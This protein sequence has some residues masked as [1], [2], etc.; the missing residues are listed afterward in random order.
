VA[1][2]PLTSM[3]NLMQVVTCTTLTRIPT[4]LKAYLSFLG[5]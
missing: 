2:L 1:K 4:H 3:Y 5:Y